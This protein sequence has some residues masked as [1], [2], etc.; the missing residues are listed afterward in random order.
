MA[1]CIASRCQRLKVQGKEEKS[2]Q[3]KDLLSDYQA[4]TATLGLSSFDGEE[5]SSLANVMGP[6]LGPKDG[7]PYPVGPIYK[8][9]CLDLGVQASNSSKLKRS[10]VKDEQGVVG[11]VAN[12]SAPAP[13]ELN[14]S[15]HNSV[16]CYHVGLL[17]QQG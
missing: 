14:P 1:G 17:D 4:I 6:E 16:D 13:P 11:S 3:R 5:R 7:V 2:F 9:K 12:H 15:L 8:L 10:S